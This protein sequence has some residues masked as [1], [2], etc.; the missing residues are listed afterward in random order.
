MDGPHPDA[1]RPI[2]AMTESTSNSAPK[3]FVARQPILDKAGGVFGYELLYRPSAAATSREIESADVATAGVIESMF[4]AGFETLVE[5]KRAFIN[6]SRRLLLAG[7][8]AVLPKDR[9]VLELGTDIEADAEVLSVCKDLKANGYSLAIDDFTLTA[10][11]AELVPLVDYVKVDFID[12]SGAAIG[13]L[14]GGH[15]PTLIAKRVETAQH[16]SKAQSAGYKLF[17]GFFLGRPV[18]KDAQ[19]VP[20]QHLASLRL[21]QA[22]NDPNLTVSRLEDLVKQDPALCFLVLRTVNSA[23]YSLRSSVQSIREAL[24]LLGRDTIRRWASLW[25]LAGLS[26]GAHT[27]LLVMATVRARCCELLAGS[28]GDDDMASEGFLVGMCSLLDA[29]LERPM[30][31][32]LESLPLPTAVREALMGVENTPRRILDCAV[33]YEEGCWDECDGLAAAAGVNPAILPS[34]YSEALKWSREIRQGT[35]GA[36]A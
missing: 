35:S 3:V 30:P 9:I 12:T 10:W 11:T 34:A 36:A 6:V 33:A 24:I 4:A 5:G 16:F 17:Q 20:A 7:I 31:T 22:L 13:P 2:F 32:V 25:A 28:G 19:A 8:P 1:R 26:Q 23:A 27:E 15:Q 18:L 29:I 21:L 14:P